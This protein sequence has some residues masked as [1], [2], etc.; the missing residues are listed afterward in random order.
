[1]PKWSLEIAVE[2][3]NYIRSINNR[4]KRSYAAAYMEHLRD[5][6]PEPTRP[7]GLTYI[8]AQAVRMRMDTI[9]RDAE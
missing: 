8:G 7:F 3:S 5:G 9:V 2:I 1:M 6:K 4:D